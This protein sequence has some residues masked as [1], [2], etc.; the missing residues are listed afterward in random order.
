MHPEKRPGLIK[1]SNDSVNAMA[2]WSLRIE[3]QAMDIGEHCSVYSE[4]R[5]IGEILDSF[6]D[7]FRGIC[8]PNNLE[9][10]AFSEE[11]AHAHSL[12]GQRYPLPFQIPNQRCINLREGT[13]NIGGLVWERCIVQGMS[14]AS[15]E[16]PG[17]ARHMGPAG[18]LF[19]R[20]HRQT[21]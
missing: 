13:A 17:P 12:P 5:S 7:F 1:H 6:D 18:I 19:Q 4:V 8:W 10:R 14:E 2:K 11:K 15:A 20:L 16:S 9:A 3:M 21:S